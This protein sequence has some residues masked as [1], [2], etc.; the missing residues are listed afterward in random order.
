VALDALA[1]TLA[2]RVQ[3]GGLIALSGI[4]QGQEAALLQRYAAWFEDLQAR[5]QDDWMRITGRRRA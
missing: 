2:A 5:Q 4:L 3:P 1:P